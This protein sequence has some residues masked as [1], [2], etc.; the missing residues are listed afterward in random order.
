M[1]RE[2]SLN[3]DKEV[4]VLDILNSRRCLLHHLYHIVYVLD[5]Y[6][7]SCYYRLKR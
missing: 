6:Y 2:V 1:F 7:F 5:C 4:S 3:A